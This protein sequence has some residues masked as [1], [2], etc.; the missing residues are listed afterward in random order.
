MIGQNDIRSERFSLADARKL[1]AFAEENGL[2][3][4]SLWSMNRDANTGEA[5]YDSTAIAQAPYDFTRLFAGFTK[6]PAT[7]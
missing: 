7:D 6:D 5:N 1:L 3:L 2:G 4:I